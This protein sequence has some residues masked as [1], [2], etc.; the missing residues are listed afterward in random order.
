MVIDVVD[1]GRRTDR[2]GEKHELPYTRLQ[3]ASGKLTCCCLVGDAPQHRHR[4]YMERYIRRALRDHPCQGGHNWQP[5]SCGA[6][7]APRHDRFDLL[8][9][10]ILVA[11]RSSLDTA[12]RIVVIAVVQG[13]SLRDDLTVSAVATFLGRRQPQQQRG[14]SNEK[15]R[16]REC[17]QIHTVGFALSFVW[18]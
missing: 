3:H 11:T 12:L 7:F 9:R 1:S 16:Q 14:C 8:V 4:A 17:I 10:R 2:R 6:D 15:H 13:R 5:F 18:R